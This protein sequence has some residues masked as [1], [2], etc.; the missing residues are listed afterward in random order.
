MYKATISGSTTGK[1]GKVFR[2]NKNDV[3]KAKRGELDHDKSLIWIE[4]KKKKPAAKTTQPKP[5]GPKAPAK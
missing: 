2:Y 3:V 1:S 4:D 5:A